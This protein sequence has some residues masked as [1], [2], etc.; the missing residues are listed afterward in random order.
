MYEYTWQDLSQQ[1]WSASEEKDIEMRNQGREAK[2][3]ISKEIRIESYVQVGT[4]ATKRP[5]APYTMIS[6]PLIFFSLASW[7]S[8]SLSDRDISPSLTRIRQTFVDNS[9]R[10]TTIEVKPRQD[11]GNKR[12]ARTEDLAFAP[13]FSLSSAGLSDKDPLMRFKV[14]RALCSS[15]NTP[16]W[17]RLD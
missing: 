17:R 14:P 10:P 2:E 4:R 1:V 12:K 8:R 3:G 9:N 5:L 11:L 6:P 13:D 16:T 7:S 15:S